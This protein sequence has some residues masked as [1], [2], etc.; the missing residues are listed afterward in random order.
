MSY[1]SVSMLIVGSISMED[2][3]IELGIS[4]EPLLLHIKA[5]TRN[6]LQAK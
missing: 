5:S 6:P 1:T 2:V 4:P 3:I